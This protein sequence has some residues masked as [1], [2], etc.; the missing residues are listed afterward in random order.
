MIDSCVRS[1]TESERGLVQ[2]ELDSCLA[3][4]A[5]VRRFAW[6]SCVAVLAAGVGV[7]AW[8]IQKDATLAYAA[9]SA[10]A[11]CIL[12]ILCVYLE[13]AATNRS[14]TASLRDALQT[15]QARVVRCRA[16]DVIQV[17]EAEGSPAEYL[18][19]VEPNRVLR[20]RGDACSRAPAFPNSDFEVV[21][22]L[23]GRGVTRF[24]RI[25]CYG[26]ALKPRRTMANAARVRLLDDPHYGGDLGLFDGSV[27]AIAGSAVN[28]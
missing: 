17:A 15:D 20:L 13:N 27:D 3:Q 23:G 18:L 22:F 12:F 4:A 5:K 6:V 14:L 1:L 7:A 26:E 9:L 28:H 11:V 21:E 2:A 24:S 10:A 25:R 16:N 19:Q 8:Q